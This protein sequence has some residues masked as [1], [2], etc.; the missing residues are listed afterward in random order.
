VVAAAVIIQ[1][2]SWG[3]FPHHLRNI[4][5]PPEVESAHF[6]WGKLQV[7]FAIFP[8]LLLTALTA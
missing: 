7:E 4:L 5:T 6:F 8:K 2:S 3:N 1:I